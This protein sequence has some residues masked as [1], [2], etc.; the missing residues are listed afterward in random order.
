MM[1]SRKI[2]SV[3]IER[4][5]KC[6]ASCCCSSVLTL[7]NLTSGYLTAAAANTGANARHGAHQGAQK[8]MTAKGWSW[9]DS[10][11][12]SS[13]SSMIACVSAMVVRYRSGKVPP[14]R[15]SRR[16]LLAAQ[17]E[18]ELAVLLA[19]LQQL[20]AGLSGEGFEVPHRRR[21]GGQD[22]QDLAAG[23]VVQRLLGAK[24][25][26]RAV[27]PAGIDFTF[28]LHRLFHHRSRP[29]RGRPACIQPV[30][31][32]PRLLAWRNPRSAR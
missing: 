13:V 21:I 30:M 14:R 18:N 10:A 23:H 17:Q 15:R 31:P 3:G 6:P 16:P 1:L 4:M 2:I 27:E 32:P 20:V 7:A 5:L 29:F 19:L 22:A 9:I 24:N 11:K 26:Q 25:G 28:E 12:F 8:S